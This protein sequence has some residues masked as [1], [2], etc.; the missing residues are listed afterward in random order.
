MAQRLT[1]NTYLNM[2]NAENLYQ[3]GLN[4][5]QAVLEKRISTDH[6]GSI[7][8]DLCSERED[9]KQA[10]IDLGKRKIFK[11]LPL[12]GSSAQMILA[13]DNLVSEISQLYRQKVVIELR[14]LIEGALGFVDSPD[15][16]TDKG[17]TEAQLP[18]ASQSGPLELEHQYFNSNEAQEYQYSQGF[19]AI[20]NKDFFYPDE[21]LNEKHRDLSILLR[22][23]KLSLLSQV[24]RTTIYQ[25]LPLSLFFATQYF[26][27]A[28]QSSPVQASDILLNLSK[29]TFQYINT[30]P[31]M[32]VSFISVAFWA[33]FIQAKQ[34]RKSFLQMELSMAGFNPLLLA[35]ATPYILSSMNEVDFQSFA[36]GFLVI[37]FANFLVARVIM[38][39]FSLYFC[40]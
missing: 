6:Y 39:I 34:A 4:F 12:T 25:L 36:G 22:S 33:A 15:E 26:F 3:I 23:K 20:E 10:L 29:L 9:I 14:D 11:D 1:I 38:A 40:H 31:W 24:S 21:N 17:Y 2:S 16:Q 30:S 28:L 7:L 18:A 35:L 37:L 32:E 27:W 19:N 13:R 5:R 8:L